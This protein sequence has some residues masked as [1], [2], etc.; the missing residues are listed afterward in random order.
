MKLLLLII[1]TYCV[2][3]SF[4]NAQINEGYIQFHIDVNAIDTT[5]E[6]RQSAGLLRNSKMEIYFAEGLSRIDFQLGELSKTSVR[7]NKKE[8]KGISISESVMG[9]YANVGTAESLA[10]ER[11]PQNDSNVT[12]TPFNE[13]KTILGFDCQKYVMD[14]NGTRSTYWCTEEITLKN[15]GQN[16]LNSNLPG[17]PL[18]FTSIEGG[19][20][21]HFQASNFKDVIPDKEEVFSTN[22]P[23]GY[24]MMDR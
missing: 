11:I 12:V 10:G 16:I 4:I 22:P 8:N 23:E 13:F 9:K 15:V 17:F 1:L 20:R 21:M 19:I 3:P 6:A 14:N 7:I 5:T 2:L 24:R 18:A